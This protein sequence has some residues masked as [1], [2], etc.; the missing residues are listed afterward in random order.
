LALTI[1]RRPGD[2]VRVRRLS[3]AAQRAGGGLTVAIGDMLYHYPEHRILQDVVTCIRE[4]CTI[5]DAGFRR[6]QHADRHLKSPAEM[7]RLFHRYP[8]AVARTVE[9]A[10]RCTFSLAELS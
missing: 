2:Q 3:D 9:I 6:E 10:A 4:G 8:E 1:R 5:D 7:A